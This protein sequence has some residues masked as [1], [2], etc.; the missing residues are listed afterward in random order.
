MLSTYHI[1]LCLVCFE[2][3]TNLIIPNSCEPSIWEQLNLVLESHCSR[4][5]PRH[6]NMWIHHKSESSLKIWRKSFLQLI[7]LVA[8]SFVT[9]LGIVLANVCLLINREEEKTRNIWGRL[10]PRANLDSET[11]LVFAKIKTNPSKEARRRVFVLSIHDTRLNWV[12][13]RM[14]EVFFH[15]HGHKILIQFGVCER[16]KSNEHEH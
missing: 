13:T 6:V 2:F 7:F 12:V 10:G 9:S 4:I 5:L 11:S 3:T 8:Q 14:G 16:E 1:T 15:C